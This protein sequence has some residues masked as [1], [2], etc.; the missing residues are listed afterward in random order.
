MKA[1]ALIPE[2]ERMIGDGHLLDG[3]DSLLRA[4]LVCPAL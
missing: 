3:Q 4:A 1:Y 2:R